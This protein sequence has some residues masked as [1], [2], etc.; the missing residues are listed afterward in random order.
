VDEKQIQRNKE[1]FQRSSEIVAIPDVIDRIERAGAYLGATVSTIL[2][3]YVYEYATKMSP[4]ESPIEVIFFTWWTAVEMAH[5]FNP[6]YLEGPRLTLTPQE[7]IVVDDHVY[8]L[9]FTVNPSYAWGWASRNA[10][11]FP[12]I[13]VELDG[14]EF[15][16]KTKEQVTYRNRRDRELQQAGW[17]VFHVSGSELSRDPL[18]VVG[19]IHGHCDKEFEKFQRA[20]QSERK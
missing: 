16:E 17:I 7:Q 11:N 3:E 5:S 8:R 12:K 15:H 13:A 14:H 1:R 19:G 6:A 20:Y 10:L 4:F 9:D 2:R 18:G